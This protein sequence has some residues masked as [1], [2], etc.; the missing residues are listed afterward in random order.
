MN[1]PLQARDVNPIEQLWDETD[2]QV[3]KMC[4]M[5][6]EKAVGQSKKLKRFKNFEFEK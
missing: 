5:I 1:W 4:M 6:S 3:R 2:W